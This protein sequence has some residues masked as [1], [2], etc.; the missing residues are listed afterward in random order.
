MKELK[1]FSEVYQYLKCIK[2]IEGLSWS[3]QE[4]VL[5]TDI[6]R[7]YFHEQMCRRY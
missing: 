3:E 5:P 4:S 1:M 6:N 2:N 7:A